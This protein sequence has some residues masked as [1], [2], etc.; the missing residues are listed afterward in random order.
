MIPGKALVLECPFCGA[1]KKLI[2][3]ESGNT[4]GGKLWSDTKGEYP[5]LP[6]PSPIQKC[7]GCGKYYFID[8]AKS[9]EGDECSFEKGELSYDELKQARCQFEN[10]FDINSKTGYKQVLYIELLY[11]YNDAFTRSD[12]SS[13]LSNEDVLYFTG[14]VN[15]LLSSDCTDPILKGELLRELGRF[16]ESVEHLKEL[17]KD[18]PDMRWVI[19]PIVNHALQKDKNPFVIPQE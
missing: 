19:D 15:E 10:S 12:S 1:K 17:Q 7:P 11:A 13:E 18:N 5:M 3:L 8:Q 6:E 14:V 9:S 4:F 2:S 16:D